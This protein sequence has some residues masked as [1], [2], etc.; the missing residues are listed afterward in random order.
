MALHS[1]LL[2]FTTIA[3][4][5]ACHFCAGEFSVCPDGSC[6]LVSSSCGICNVSQ[7]AC[8]LSKHC[9]NSIDEYVACPQLAGTHLD[10]RLAEE[11]R[12]D[13]LVSRVNISQMIKQLVNNAPAIEHVAVPAYNYLND[14]MHANVGSTDTTVYPMGVGLGASWSVELVHEVGVAMGAA[15]RATHNVLPDKSGNNCASSSTG[16]TVSNGCGITLYAPNINMLRDPR[17]GRAEEVFGEDPHL[18]SELAVA[19]V[20]GMQGN[21]EG[22]RRG[23]DGGALMT[24]AGI[25]HLAVYNSETQPKD[26]TTLN[27]NVTSRDLWE[28]YLPAFK[29]AVVR[30][31]ASHVMC[32]YN[33]V[34]GKPT[35]AHDELLTTILRE[36]WGFDGFVVSDYDAWIN[37]VT[38][39]HYASDFEDAAAK[40]I[41]AGMDQ[42]GGFGTYTVIDK[43]ADAL[44]SGK[45]KTDTVIEAFRRLMR[46]RMRLGMFDPPSQV[47]PMGPQYRPSLQSQ[48]NKTLELARRAARESF[49]LLKNK[50]SVLPLNLS[51]L[52]NQPHSLA[53]VGPQADDWRLLMGAANYA[54]ASGP[55]KGVVTILRGLQEAVNIPGLP[56]ALIS[57]PG[58][59][60][61]SC[62]AVDTNAA[63]LAASD[64]SASIVILGTHFGS[65]PGWP[66][67]H[68]GTTD[69]CESEAHD[70]TEIELP[71]NQVKLVLAMRSATRGPLIC[72]LI[73]GGAVALGEASDACDAILDLWVPGQMAGVALADV[74]FG[75]VSPAGRS[76]ITFYS[77]T[78]DL[79]AMGEYNEY[80]HEGSNGTTYRY[81]RGAPPTFRFGYGL[82]YTTFEYRHLSAPRRVAPC[83]KIVVTVSV[84]NTGS[85]TSDEVVQ[86]YASVPNATVPA[87]TIRLVAFRKVR[88][89]A[90]SRSAIVKLT[91]EPES[92]AVVLPS[93][94]PYKPNLQVEAGH[95]QLFV[96]GSQPGDGPV[97]EA[98][99]MVKSSASLDSCAASSDIGPLVI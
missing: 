61:V 88:S 58:C 26:R 13:R 36:Q 50:G 92:H 37:L 44:N 73:H 34:N 60:N 23:A 14:D 79:P 64:A 97:L 38:T 62:A 41:N 1:A 85:Y 17:W 33:A 39:H 72:L 31:K 75:A 93:S 5:K 68:G 94:S 12:L 51:L 54:P 11:E 47:M 87:P 56:A 49:V 19:I 76:P 28:T 43:M 2:I 70:R 40:G 83:D 48:T 22:S 77:A 21:E 81:Y 8:P 89:I 53:L 66:L 63:A 24:S 67:C 30:G 4:T 98:L 29:A 3:T 52:R 9:F 74:L 45:V 84:H 99:V 42:E 96:G 10:W 6:A 69:G 35:C 90:P 80:P 57:V 71:G 82:S 27:V 55:S 20:T 65:S 7:Y 91:I 32:S 95:L 16:K 25:K 86:V 78:A 15:Q 59:L 46:V 18:T